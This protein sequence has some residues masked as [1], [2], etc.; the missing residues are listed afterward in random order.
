M[1]SLTR[2][3]PHRTAQMFAL[4]PHRTAQHPLKGV[5]SCAGGA[6]RITTPISGHTHTGLIFGATLRVDQPDGHFYARPI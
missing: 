5:R 2:T 1:A 4:V 6:V 3:E